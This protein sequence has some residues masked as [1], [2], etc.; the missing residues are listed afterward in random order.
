MHR[1]Y[2]ADLYRAYQDT[3]DNCQLDRTWLGTL[4]NRR[5]GDVFAASVSKLRCRENGAI[6]I[7]ALAVWIF[8]LREA[9]N[10]AKPGCLEAALARRPTHEAEEAPQQLV[11]HPQIPVSECHQAEAAP[12]PLPTQP[13]APVHESHPAEAPP[14]PRSEHHMGEAAPRRLSKSQWL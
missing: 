4:G 10:K 2:Y 1:E 5:L 11:A 6:G 8:A 14:R 7:W 3:F 9:K 13:R 12:M